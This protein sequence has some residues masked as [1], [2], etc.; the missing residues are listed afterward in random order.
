MGVVLYSKLV[1]NIMQITTPCFHCTP[2]LMN[3]GEQNTKVVHPDSLDVLDV[4]A[5][6]YAGWILCG[7]RVRTRCPYA[8]AH[9]ERN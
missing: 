4:T 3:L 5:E 8:E 6:I 9:A 1:H 7:L 2:P